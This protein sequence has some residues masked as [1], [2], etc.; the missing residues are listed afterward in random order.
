MTLLPAVGGEKVD[1]SKLFDIFYGALKTA[2][3]IRECPLCIECRTTA[4]GRSENRRAK[5]GTRVKS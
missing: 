2:P 5:R 3:M 4:T 1:M